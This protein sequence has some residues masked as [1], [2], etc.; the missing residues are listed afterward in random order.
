M[1][2][3][4]YKLLD[5]EKSGDF[6]S[7]YFNYYNRTTRFFCEKCRDIKEETETLSFGIYDESRRPDWTYNLN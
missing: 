7:R 6:S 2:E 5:V 4:K 1:C 3:H